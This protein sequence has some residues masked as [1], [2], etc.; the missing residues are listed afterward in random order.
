MLMFSLRT[1]PET[2]S[3]SQT[4]SCDTNKDVAISFDKKVD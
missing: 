4:A 2:A 3:L 1:I